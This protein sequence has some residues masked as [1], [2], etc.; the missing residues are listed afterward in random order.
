MYAD[1]VLHKHVAVQH[2]RFGAILP[3][4]PLDHPRARRIWDD[5]FPDNDAAERAYMSSKGTRSPINVLEHISPPPTQAAAPGITSAVGPGSVAAS[6]VSGRSG[7]VSDTARPAP[8]VA[9]SVWK[10]VG[11]MRALNPTRA[12]PPRHADH[13]RAAGSAIGAAVMTDDVPRDDPLT[14]MPYEAP[15]YH[16]G[17]P[18]PLTPTSPGT[19]SPSPPATKP[20]ISSNIAN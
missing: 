1:K 9:D 16:W 12:P 3:F 19:T 2:I 17:I 4:E 10:P 13:A 8:S 5:F 18:T 15:F 7:K 11:L 6:S 14:T 20:K